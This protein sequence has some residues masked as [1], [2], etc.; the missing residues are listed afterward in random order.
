MKCYLVPFLMMSLHINAQKPL[1]FEQGNMIRITSDH[2]NYFLFGDPGFGALSDYV[3]SIPI[4][5]VKQEPKEITQAE[6]DIGP[7]LA[8][9]NFLYNKGHFDQALHLVD[10]ALRSKKDSAKAWAMRGSLMHVM[11]YQQDALRSWSKSFELDPKS[12]IQE[13]MAKIK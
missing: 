7:L 6:I 5:S 1:V 8:K 13:Q 2:G 12:D 3:F 9:A 10:E 11:G 4:V